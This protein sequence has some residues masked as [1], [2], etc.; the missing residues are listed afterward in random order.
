MADEQHPEEAEAPASAVDKLYSMTKQT[1]NA[2][3]NMVGKVIEQ[4]SKTASSV[5]GSASQVAGIATDSAKTAVDAVG[6]GFDVVS[7]KKIMALLEERLELPAQYNDVLATKLEEAL[8]RIATLEE[9]GQ[10]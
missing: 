3:G 1:A 2:A 9:K 8:G 7:G 5:A 10:P 6:D 4:G